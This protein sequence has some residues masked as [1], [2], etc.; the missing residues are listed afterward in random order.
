MLTRWWA[1]LVSMLVLLVGCTSLP[2]PLQPHPDLVGRWTD[3]SGQELPDGSAEMDH[4]VVAYTFLASTDCSKRKDTVYL[5]LAWPVGQ[6]VTR[7]ELGAMARTRYF[8]R[9]TMGEGFQTRGDF[10]AD[11]ELPPNAQDT[12]FVRQGNRIFV[13][14]S[15]SVYVTRPDG[16]AERWQEMELGC[17]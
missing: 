6:I 10:D 17:A 4:A 15:G 11:A 9:G 12:G 3:A 2:A 7:D 5:V 13:D 1:A 14:R 8:V 16:R